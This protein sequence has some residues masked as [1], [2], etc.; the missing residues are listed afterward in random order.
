MVPD[1]D[2]A[3]VVVVIVEWVALAMNDE[4]REGWRRVTAS[5]WGE[6][7]GWREIP[8]AERRGRRF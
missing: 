1:E 6:H 2:G 4:D 8:D 5:G 7:P 3:R